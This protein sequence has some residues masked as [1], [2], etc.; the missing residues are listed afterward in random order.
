MGANQT[1]GG[2]TDGLE[3]GL[4]DGLADGLE[5]KTVETERTLTLQDAF[6]I[7]M[8]LDFETLKS[9]CKP[10]APYTP[11]VIVCKN[12]DFW[13]LKARN[14]GLI[15][16]FSEFNRVRGFAPSWQ[17]HRIYLALQV[18][19]VVIDLFT[20]ARLAER[21]P[22]ASEE[23]YVAALRV[24]D[25]HLKDYFSKLI[26]EKRAGTSTKTSGEIARDVFSYIHDKFFPM[27]EG[28]STGMLN[29][30]YVL[31][32]LI[33]VSTDLAGAWAQKNGFGS[34][35]FVEGAEEARNIAIAAELVRVLKELG[36]DEKP[37]VLYESVEPLATQEQQPTTMYEK[38]LADLNR[39]R[40]SQFSLTD[41]DL[42]I[43]EDLGDNN[44]RDMYRSAQERNFNI[45]KEQEIS[46]LRSRLLSYMKPPFT[47]QQAIDYGILEPSTPWKPELDDVEPLA[48]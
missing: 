30:D 19:Q 28:L 32:E 45:E 13:R 31:S 40:S 20:L 24:Y 46:D 25:S 17:P 36:M 21:V 34:F 7:A 5:L 6:R 1:K 8:Q 9:I 14:D 39:V 15:T 43:L 35:E 3:D 12:E 27:T 38:T 2:L 22:G 16:D 4:E 18:P 41:E 48:I 37:Y 33:D 44:E 23:D 47:Q 42:S 10:G 29:T 11:F 26:R